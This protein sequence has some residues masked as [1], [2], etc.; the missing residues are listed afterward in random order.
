MRT[1]LLGTDFVYNSDGNL[2]PIEINTQVGISKFCIEDMDN[3]FDLTNLTSFINS[4]NFTKITYIGGL[5][6]FSNKLSIYCSGLTN[7]IDYEYI[8]ITGGVT[9]PDI[10]D[11]DEHLII[12][13]AYDY[14]AIVDDV[15]CKDKVN[16]M[17]LIKSKSF[18]SQFA[19]Y[20]D[21][22]ILVNNI[23]TIKDNGNLPNFILKS[24]Y[25]IYDKDIY[26]KFYKVET[27][28]ELNTVLQNM[29]PG[30]FLMDFHYNPNKL[31][32]FHLT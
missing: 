32:Y 11:T 17:N 15:Y 6:N 27:Q 13:S 31:Y 1:V 7:P 5:I 9:V 19:Y 25:P 28:E 23:N 26:P 4:N 24:I 3:I 21:N 16:F 20:D 8:Q 12:R 14:S 2:V 30:Y 10:E 18:G 29:G 22:E